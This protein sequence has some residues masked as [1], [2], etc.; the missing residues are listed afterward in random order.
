M[1]VAQ[2]W[3]LHEKQSSQD[4]TSP[5]SA[6]PN[7]PLDPVQPVG[8]QAG[9]DRQREPESERER[10][11]GTR[12]RE[13]T[14]KVDAKTP[15]SGSGIQSTSK[16][17]IAETPNES[18]E[19]DASL[20]LPDLLSPAEKMKSS[21]EKYSEFI[22]PPLEEEWTPAHSCVPT[23]NKRPE[24]PEEPK[25]LVTAPIP[26]TKG[27]EESKVDYLPI[28]LLSTILDP[29]RK[30]IRVAPT[31]LVTFGEMTTLLSVLELIPCLRLPKL[32][33]SEDRCQTAP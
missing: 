22:M 21:W 20:K 25:D 11:R 16:A 19:K 23:L 26:E 29:E 32:R 15:I 27:L 1:D 10:A 33:R 24:A 6:S 7:S 30:I 12:E 13:E 31:D 2:V 5:R 28:D 3:S 9:L 4:V 14:P 18:E 8:I 17:S